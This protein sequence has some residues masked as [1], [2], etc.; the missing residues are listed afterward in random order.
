MKRLIA[1]ITT[2]L[3]LVNLLV[4]PVSAAEV[5]INSVYPKDKTSYK[6]G[7]AA[8][9][10]G[11]CTTG[12]DIVIRIYDEK[13]SLIFTDVILATDNVSG[14]FEFSGFNIPETKSK[15]E[16]KYTVV[17]SQEQD[18][19]ET[20]NIDKKT[21]T[22]NPKE[23][24]DTIGGGE[25]KILVSWVKKSGK[26]QEEEKATDIPAYIDPI[27]PDKEND[28]LWE[29]IGSV[30]STT[31]AEKA[32]GSITKQTSKEALLDETARNNVAVAGETMIAN[33]SS[34]KI[35]VGR[36]NKVVLDQS[37]VT[38]NDLSK[39]DNATKA[40]EKAIKDNS[41]SL[42]R[43]M[44]KELVITA[45]FNKKT[46]AEVAISKAL[47]EKIEKANVDILSIKDA[48]FKI[49]YTM[50][51]IKSILGDKDETVLTIDKS[52]ITKDAKK[53]AVTFDT[54][55]TKTMKIAFSGLSGNT[56][57]MAV[58]DENGNPVGGRYNPATGD[59]EAKISESG[60]YSVV[61]NEKE[62][63]DIKH[64]SKEM[65]ESIKIL[66]AKGIIE[67]TAEKEFSPENSISRAEI[68]ALLLRVLS[69]VDPNSDGGFADVKK[70]DWFF[71]TA[72]SAKK[73]GMIIGFEDNTFRGNLTISK[74]QI[75]TIAS[76]VLQKEM[77]YKVP[78]KTSEWLGFY[79]NDTIAEWAKEHIALTSMAN[80]IT[81]TADNKIHANE[82]MTRGDA[83]LIIM[84]L[85]YKIW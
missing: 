31:D 22:I 42:N 27:N 13:S 62:F 38:A 11:T 74:D 23:K 57:Y 4:L 70:T 16:L 72:G 8:V 73:Y 33:I 55:N 40:I 15:G 81:R 64:L 30:N 26:D 54:D 58:V 36:T 60:V 83:A 21:I 76:R 59:F 77:K 12:K 9:I 67:G 56:D 47:V 80:I 84:R 68:A 45:N 66:A 51:E 32:I 2:L 41:I 82:E 63:D 5:S 10:T 28:K 37:A 24:T 85:F 61:N 35:T 79:D 1:L 7:E 49:S 69:Q 52:G 65:Q 20:T 39:L 50:A 17:V 78:E 46:I 14:E 25:E 44:Q 53:I 6:D 18:G 48:D 43:E 71:G 34:K 19:E 75:L 29:T 3:I